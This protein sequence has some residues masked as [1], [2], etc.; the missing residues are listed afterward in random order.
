M[1]KQEKRLFMASTMVFLQFIPVL[2]FLGV[3]LYGGQEAFF[4]AIV[5]FGC[6]APPLILLGTLV[7]A[8]AKEKKIQHKVLAA[9]L[10]LNLIFTM[11]FWMR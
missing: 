2:I 9:S 11:W 10:V 6:L 8:S 1:L 3:T 4:L 7:F 5:G